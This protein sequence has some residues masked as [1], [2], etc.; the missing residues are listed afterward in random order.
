MASPSRK[1]CAQLG[2]HRVGNIAVVRCEAFKGQ[3]LQC[4]ARQQSLRLS[5]LH[6]HRRFAPA[7][8][9]VVHTRHIV[10]HQ[11]VGMDQLHSACR[12]HRCIFHPSHLLASS[13]GFHTGQNQKW[14]QTFSTIQHR[15]T[16]G[17]TQAC[18][19]VSGNPIIQSHFDGCQM[20]LAPL[21]E[22]KSFHSLPL[23]CFK[24][25]ASSTLICSSTACNC[26]R[27]WLNKKAPRW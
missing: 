25:P 18:R 12:T 7:Q 21:V 26:A 15:V 14:A 6:M 2:L 9:I 10:M 11:T 27:Q 5:K 3:R 4:V 19:R 13:T 22:I 20:G 1:Q 24:V 16:H 23:H 17:L 8:H